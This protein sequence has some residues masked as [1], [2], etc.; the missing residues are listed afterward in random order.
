M[1][2]ALS[3]R[4][5]FLAIALAS[6]LLLVLRSRPLERFNGGIEPLLYAT[7]LT[8]PRA[9][10]SLPDGTILAIDGPDAAARVVEIDVDGSVSAYTAPSEPGAALLARSGVW[11]VAAARD[12]TVYAT[13]REEGLL[14]E[15]AAGGGQTGTRE[16][17]RFAGAGAPN[18]QPTGVTVSPDGTVYVALFATQPGRQTSGA[19]ARVERDGRWTTVFDGLTAPV[20]VGFDREGQLYVLEA[21]ERY[22]AGGGQLSRANGRLMTLGPEAHQ[23]RTIARGIDRPTGMVFTPAG[24]LYLTE[25]AYETAPGEAHLLRV[26]AQGLRPSA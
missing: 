1:R 9:L 8:L 21:A 12:G 20:A 18:P 25:R 10:A 24:D 19:V 13:V 7:G 14:I 3:P 26:P 15:I 11:A 5:A 22:D 4:A 23:R 2:L 17:V 16:V 6:G